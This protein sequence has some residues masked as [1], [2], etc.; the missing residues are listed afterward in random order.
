MLIV[1]VWL[2]VLVMIWLLFIFRWSK[3]FA[4]DDAWLVRFQ[5]TGDT[6]V[7]RFRDKCHMIL[8]FCDGM[9]AVVCWV[10][11]VL[12][13]VN[14]RHLCLYVIVFAF[15][16]HICRSSNYYLCRYGWTLFSNRQYVLNLYWVNIW[17]CG[18]LMIKWL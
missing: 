8:K 15:F 5:L 4:Q 7:L 18:N 9:F 10:Q 1:L 2:S 16:L 6:S 3:R 13:N 17:C 11:I 12:I 14:V